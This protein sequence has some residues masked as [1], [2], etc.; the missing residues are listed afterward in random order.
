MSPRRR[1]AAQVAL[2]AALRNAPA[3]QA[4]DQVMRLQVDLAHVPHWARIERAE[5]LAALAEAQKVVETLRPVRA[6]PT[7]A[8]LWGGQ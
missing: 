5:A 6:A 2:V 7:L 1:P 8:T 3:Q 4:Q